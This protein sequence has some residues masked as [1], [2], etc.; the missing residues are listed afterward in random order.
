MFDELARSNAK[1]ITERSPRR[2]VTVSPHCLNTFKK[3]YP[4]LGVPVI[5]HSQLLAELLD[6]GRLTVR[7]PLAEVVTFHDPC[8]LGRQNK[9]FEEPRQIL[10][11]LAG[12]RFVELDR[13]REQSLCCEGGGGRMWVESA[14]KGRLAEV[15]VHDAIDISATVLATACP[16][17]ILT[18]EDAVK[19][20]DSDAR[21]RIRDIAELIAEAL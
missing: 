9:V 7:K 16:F 14:G 21:I 6:S 19:T 12:D 17:C 10:T 20:T 5:H 15:R 18:L 11:A 3:D 13:S 2:V 1:L 8:Y 4:D